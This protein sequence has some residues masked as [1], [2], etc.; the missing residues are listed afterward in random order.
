MKFR[1][2]AERRTK[3]NNTQAKVRQRETEKNKDA[4]TYSAYMETVT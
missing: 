4:H 1:N 2:T 3:K